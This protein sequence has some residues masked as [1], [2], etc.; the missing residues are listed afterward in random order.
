MTSWWDRFPGRL[1]HEL[2]DFATRELKFE[3]DETLFRGASRL[4]LRGNI[5]HKGKP[6]ALEIIYPDLFPYFR[7]EVYAPQLRLGRHQNPLLGNLCLLDRPSTA[8]KPHETGAW[9]IAERVPLLLSLLEASPEAIRAGEAPQGEPVSVYFQG[10][11]GM[12]II[13]PEAALALDDQLRVGSG[14]L[15][16]GLDMPPQLSIRALLC[17]LTVRAHGQKTKIIAQAEEPLQQRFGGEEAHMRWVRLDGPPPGFDAEAI[18]AAAEAVQPGFGQPPWQRGADGEFAVTGVVFG[19]EVR[20]GV[21]ED[22][23]LFAVRWQRTAGK[24]LNQGSYALRGERLTTQDLGARIPRLAPLHEATIA[25]IGLGALGAPLAL[26]LARNQVAKLRLLEFDRVEGSQIVRW[27]FGVDA[28]GR[29]KLGVIDRFIQA[30]YP[31]TSIEGFLHRL[32]QSAER[33][34]RNESELE[35]LD[36]LLDGATLIVDASAENRLQQLVADLAREREVD[37]VFL[38]ATEGARGG[39]VALIVPG[40]GGCWLCW[41]LHVEDEAIPLPPAEEGTGVQ[42]RGC[43]SSTFTGASFDLLPIVA[44]AA[45]VCAAALHPAQAIGSTVWICALPEDPIGPPAWSSHPIAVHPRCPVC[46]PAPAGG[47]RL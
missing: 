41:K 3:V 4:L 18:F 36:R 44:H 10:P 22:G 29:W 25:Q 27:P 30:N 24:I 35:L 47:P 46:S 26:E 14:K 11:P 43:G 2:E 33:Q 34:D 6:V 20:Q 28:I 8:W 38:S 17:E 32:G 13:V 40:R 12:T 15:R 45:R 21:I 23:W 31:Y 42:P 39:Q 16:F 19:E 9:L 5:D 7:P 37:Q 1:E